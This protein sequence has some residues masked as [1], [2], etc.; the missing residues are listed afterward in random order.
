MAYIKTSSLRLPI[1]YWK[2]QE[3]VTDRQNCKRARKTAKRVQT[4]N[5]PIKQALLFSNALFSFH[6]SSSLKSVL[7]L[8]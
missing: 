1:G 4:F 3:E 8:V 7:S 6:F 5:V 2:P